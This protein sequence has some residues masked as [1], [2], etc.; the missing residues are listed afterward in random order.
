[1]CNVRMLC[2]IVAVLAVPTLALAAPQEFTGTFKPANSS[3]ANGT[4]RLTLDGSTLTVQINATGLEPNQNHPQH[5]HGF[6]DD[7]RSV[8]PPSP[9]TPA[10]DTNGN[11]ML[12]DAEGEVFIG[13]PLV[14]LVT[15]PATAQFLGENPNPTDY[16]AAGADGSLTYNQTFTI[17]PALVEPLDLRVVEI[18]GLTVSGT[19]DATLPVA[20]AQISAS[21]TGGG[22]GGNPIPLPPGA[23]AGIATI[24]I[25]K[26][27]S[28]LKYICRMAA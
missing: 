15:N 24:A 27:K 16:P 3:G 20:G 19:Y 18:H 25:I 7:R 23:W 2:R 9:L 5:I 11:G 26:G 17:D 13:P 8:I 21:G 28:A 14:S 1:M 4:T 6:A 10:I 22:G 12:E